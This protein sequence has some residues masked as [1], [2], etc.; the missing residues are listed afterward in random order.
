[1]VPARFVLELALPLL[2]TGPWAQA[3]VAPRSAS[4]DAGPDRFVLPPFAQVE[5]AGGFRGLG[6]AP[7]HAPSVSWSQTAGAPVQIQAGASLRP[8]VIASRPGT[9]RLRL[10]VNEPGFPASSDD[11]SVHFLGA[12][13]DGTQSGEPRKWS[14]VSLDFV[15]DVSLNESGSPNPFF[16]LRLVVHFFEPVAGLVRSVPGFFAAD[17]DAAESGV[18]AGTIWRVH[19]TPDAAGTWYYVADFR[20][21]PGLA[22]D[23]DLDAGTPASFDGANGSFLVEPTDPAAPGLLAKGRLEWVAKHHLRFAETGEYFLKNGADSP[24]NFLAYYE[25]DSTSDQGGLANDLNTTGAMD[26]LHH[27]DAHALDHVD[28]GVPLWR[29]GQGQRIFGAVNYLSSRG[30][31]SLYALTFNID[32]GDG[33]EVWPWSTPTSKLRYDVSKL[34]QWER[35]VDHMTRAGIVW[36]VITQET[37]NDHMLDG[38]ALGSQRKLYY[39]ELIA[40]FG[41]APGLIWNLGEENSNS[42]EERR[43]FADYIRATDPYDHPIAIHNRVSDL[44]GTFGPLLGTHLEIASLQGDPSV[45]PSSARQL[46]DDSAAAGRPWVVGFDEQNPAGDGV[47]PDAL[48]FWHDSIRQQALWPMLLGQSGGCEWYFGYNHPHSD[49]DCEDFRSRENL[50]SLATLARRFVED[51]APFADMEHANA[52]ATGSAPSVLALRGRIYLVYLPT[53]GPSSLNLET[54]AGT[55]SVRWFDARDGGSLATGSVAAI[56]GPGQRSLGTPPGPGDWV[57]LVRNSANLPPR[58]DSA[59]IEPS[60]YVAGQDFAVRVH[61]SD[62]DGPSDPLSARLTLRD[63]SGVQVFAA[64]LEPRGGSLYSYFSPDAAVLAPGEW[65]IVVR[66]DDAAGLDDVAFLPFVVP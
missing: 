47:V 62:P 17:G 23:P 28:L 46:V 65:K 21:G 53:G 36:H 45:I 56:T 27:F 14:K 49:V 40:R 30:V 55:F 15:H 57:A 60:T 13:Q 16:D 63:P 34:A 66:V 64:P 38:G 43:D 35:V 54:H 51:H 50:W 4:A 11:V 37:E 20:A 8:T 5:L 24:E 61:A 42:A 31:N 41:H 10:T 26:G 19:F 59:T 6:V 52:L 18:G 32:G 29:G 9:V 12:D 39:R 58:I 22:I 3:Q 25:F 44:S 48:D 2:L 33:R 1:M 7:A